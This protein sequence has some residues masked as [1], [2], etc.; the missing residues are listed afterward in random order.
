[1]YDELI[2][3][4]GESD[5][6]G[7]EFEASDEEEE[8][9]DVS[10]H[11]GRRFPYKWASCAAIG[12]FDDLEEEEAVVFDAAIKAS[13]RD[14]VNGGAPTSAGSAS[15][16]RAAFTPVTTVHRFVMEQG[17][18]V[19]SDLVLD[20]D[21]EGEIP[22]L[23]DSK[24]EPIMQRRMDRGKNRCRDGLQATLEYDVDGDYNGYFSQQGREGRRP[25][26][27]D[28]QERR[29]LKYQLG[30]HLTHISLAASFHVPRFVFRQ[31]SVRVCPSHPP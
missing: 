28:K 7:S 12:H 6:S 23:T 24:D 4:Q 3:P 25:D 21:F 9:R 27:V 1:M 8:D 5:S 31:W 29:T 15:C 13:I 26:L 22:A 30:R 2:T 18:G 19:D 20:N 11:N 17:F 16:I 14:L 10:L